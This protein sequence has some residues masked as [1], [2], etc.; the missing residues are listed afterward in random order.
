MMMKRKK[1]H[2]PRTDEFILCIYI[3][4]F[5]YGNPCKT[6]L[7]NILETSIDLLVLI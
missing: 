7:C 1:N 2:Q 3:L 4:A 5:S 6:Y